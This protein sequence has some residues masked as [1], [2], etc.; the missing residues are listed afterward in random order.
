M[1]F[2]AKP[3][4]FLALTVILWASTAAGGFAAEKPSSAIP[5]PEDPALDVRSAAELLRGYSDEEHAAEARTFPGRPDPAIGRPAP[6]TIHV[7]GRVFRD[8]NRNERPDR[9]EP[10][11]SNVLVTDGERVLRTQED[12]TFQFTFEMPNEPHCRFVVATRP[13][14]FRPTSRPVLSIRF[15]ALETQYR[16]AFGFV[17]DPG[18]RRARFS[19][20]TASDS[21]FTQPAEMIAIAK[22]YA[23]VTS[24][25]GDPAFLVTAG[26]LTM[27]GTHYEWDMYDR[28]RQASKI[29]V[30]DGFGGHDGNCLQPRC[31]TNFELRIGPPYYS[32]DYGGVHFVQFVSELGYLH[33]QARRR[34]DAWLRADLKAIPKGMPVIAL[35]H[36]PLDPAWFDS[37]RAEGV[38]VIGQIAAHWHVVMAGSRSGVPVLISAPARGRDWGAYSR[39]YRQVHVSPQ[40]LD[41]E[42]RVAGQYRRLKAF[43]PGPTTVLGTQ[44]LVVLAYDTARKVASVRCRVVA[45]DGTAEARPLAGEGDWSWHG[46]FHATVPGRWTI[47]L[48]ATDE[49][50]QAWHR[51][52]SVSVR[53][54]QFAE[55]KVG[56]DFPSILAGHPPRCVET[57][58]GAPLYPLWVKHTGAVHVLFSSPVVQAGRV[59]VAVT[60]PN[61]GSPGAGVL[62]LDGRTGEEVWRTE[63]KFGDFRGTV[64]VHDNKVF[65]VTAEGWAV[66][67][68]AAGGNLLWSRPL[69]EDYRRGRP[70]AT[71][72]TPPIP[73]PH[74]LLVSDWQKPQWLLDYS[75]GEPFAELGGDAG[76]YAAFATVFNGVMYTACRG[77]AIAL[78]V[79][80]GEVVWKAEETS[81]STSAGVLADGRLLYTTQ[82]GVKA[83][84]AA[85]GRPLWQA[86]VANNG[87][88]KPIPVVWDNLVLVNG[89]NPAAV[90]LAT[91]K[92]VWTVECGTGADRFVRSRRHVLAGSSTPLVAGDLAYFGHDDT[93]VRAVNKVG[94]VVWEHRVGTP[95]KTSP[96]V[97]GNLL[98]VYDHAG[99]MWCFCGPES[100][101]D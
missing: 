19:F 63:S 86:P 10:G 61:A 20:L 44:P 1:T 36:Y 81:R 50:G 28:I 58:P 24:G 80:G 45:P 62:C 64:T 51:R 7:T 54:R 3:D 66:A 94:R 78:K 72:Q 74:G 43:A 4:C 53:S 22:D 101:V 17:D 37:R 21:Q 97:S 13:T 91:G 85:T 56:A 84:D 26:D 65:A 57:G 48:E 77:G 67:Y 90:E 27:N 34:H 8:D 16:A 33:P 25:A 73:T 32:W 96:A 6:R 92:A 93:S 89:T 11:L 75:T 71:N 79:P 55:A 69:R 15:D 68:D 39:T 29:D 31:S 70:L 2:S 9:A 14:G 60:N 47:E 18:S 76:Y 42:L 83:V 95:V 98:F 12:G 38:N 5:V 35:S 82:G 99:N 52:Q 100:D 88:Q 87:Y 40:G 59:Y 41:S 30:Y 23:Q 49:T 46:R